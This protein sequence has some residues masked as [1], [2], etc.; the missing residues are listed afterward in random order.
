MITFKD[1]KSYVECMQVVAT[2]IIQC[3]QCTLG[4]FMNVA[5]VRETKFKV[6]LMGDR[7]W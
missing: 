4:Q 1:K 7:V 2:Q 3:I 5:G 6:N